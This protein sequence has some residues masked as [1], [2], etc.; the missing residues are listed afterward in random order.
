M[1]KTRYSFLMYGFADAPG[2]RMMTE[3]YPLVF[4]FAPICIMQITDFIITLAK[5]INDL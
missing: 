2:M 4:L 1:I 3:P 5:N